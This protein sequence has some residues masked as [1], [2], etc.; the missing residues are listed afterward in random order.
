[1]GDQRIEEINNHIKAARLLSQVMTLAFNFIQENKQSISE[2]QVQQFLVQR[3]RESGL[4]SDASPP[5][6]A[7]G[8]NTRHVHY[9]PEK[10]SRRLQENDLIL[11]DIWAKLPGQNPYADITWMGYFGGNLDPE[12]KSK[13]EFVFGA[14]NKATEYLEESLRKGQIPTGDE[15]DQ[16][17]RDYFGEHKEHFRHTLGHSLGFDS[18]HGKLGRLGP[19]NLDPLF[20]SVGY[21]IEPGLYFDLFGARSEIDF[22]IDQEKKLRITTPAQKKL[23]FIR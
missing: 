21:T 8:P 2:Y 4:V 5:I 1:M 3:F 15:I 22:Y 19:G 14:R 9:F 13:V 20:I 11:I 7:F 18:P 16:I 6:V 10:D 23:V 12:I 17:V